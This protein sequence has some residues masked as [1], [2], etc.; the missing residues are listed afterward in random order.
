MLYDNALLTTAYIEG[1]Q[2]TGDR[3]TVTSSRK[4]WPHITREMTSPE[5]PYHSTQDADSE[6]VEVGSSSGRRRKSRRFWPETAKVFKWVYGSR[7]KQLGRAQHPEPTRSYSQD[8]RL[9]QIASWNCG[10]CWLRL[11]RSY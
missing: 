2:A 1:F 6:G 7:A 4:R 11:V 3:P 8:S 10:K 5:G 9:M